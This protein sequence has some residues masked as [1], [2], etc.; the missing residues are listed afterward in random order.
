MQVTDETNAPRGIAASKATGVA[1]CL[2]ATLP[3]M[4]AVLLVPVLPEMLKAFS[5]VPSAS[6]W[7]P[8]L[9]SGPALAMA[10]LAP[11]AGWLGDRFGRRKLLLIAAWTYVILAVLP[12]VITDFWVIFATRLLLGAATTTTLVLSITMVSDY[13]EDES[14]DR[15]LAGQTAMATFAA[16]LLIPLGGLLGSLLGWRGAFLGYLT[17][18][19][20]IFAVIWLVPAKLAPNASHT[21]SSADRLASSDARL[22]WLW[23]SGIT[24]ITILGSAMFHAVQ[25]QIGL[26]FAAV[27]VTEP[28]QVGV[29]SAIAIAGMPLGAFAFWKVARTPFPLL[30]AAEFI[31]I[32]LTLMGMWWVRTPISLVCVAF[33]NLVGC[34]LLLP[35]LIT[36]VSNVLDVSVRARGIGLWQAAFGLGQFLSPAA[37]ALVLARSGTNVLDAFA[38]LG[39]V[40]CTF[41]ILRLAVWSAR[42][43]RMPPVAGEV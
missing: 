24:A 38:A 4:T 28:G 30:L 37:I 5:Q 17:T 1:L 9:L 25:L 14:R 11:A 34:G 41:G 27:G 7:V 18:V 19:P 35:T 16:L 36:H 31:F 20:I 6:L 10:L 40:A 2:M 29:L 33:L 42:N 22:P 39:I 12:Y 43:D 15:W 3:V 23:L 8:S 13:F 26:A 32:G 21:A